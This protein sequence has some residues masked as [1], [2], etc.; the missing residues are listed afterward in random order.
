MIFKIP[1]TLA[2]VT[3]AMTLRPGDVIATGTPDG[4]GAGQN[5]PVY[6][7]AGDSVEVEIENIGILRST[8]T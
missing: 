5:P 3:R 1:E 4:V 2:Y 8:V 6:M 7:H